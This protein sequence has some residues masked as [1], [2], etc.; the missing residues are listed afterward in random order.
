MTDSPAAADGPRTAEP[1]G[2]RL[3]DIP[4]Q[5]G[6]WLPVAAGELVR[7]TDVEGSQIADMFAVSAADHDEWLGGA[8]TRSGLARLF[9]RVGEAFL[10]NRLR[11]ILTFVEDNTPGVH[12]L[13]YRACDP[14]MYAHAGVEGWHPSCNENF[15]INAAAAGWT[16]PDVPD[17]VDFFQNSPP[18][19]HGE[20]VSGV[21]PTKAGDNVVLR[22]ELDLLIVVTACSWDL[23]PPSVNGDR[24]TGIRLEVL[25]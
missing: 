6:G 10:T 18:D 24:C 7:I 22:A 2:S 5:R 15:R 23:N 12:D 8:H 21:G 9:P 25:S 19:A 13:L 4:P 1:G 14:F 16:P 3:V 20:L 11:P 17:P